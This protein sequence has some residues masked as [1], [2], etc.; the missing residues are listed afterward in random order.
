MA[1]SEELVA[2]YQVAK[3]TLAAAKERFDKVENELVQ[4]M[5]VQEI[6]SDLVCV[7]GKDYKVTVV[8]GESV[9]VDEIGLEK[10]LG[11]RNFKRLCSYR[12]DKKLLEA[13]LTDPSIPLSAETAA[14]FITIVPNKPYVKVSDYKEEE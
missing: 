6:K 9:R 12:V 3:A 1:I 7:R 2:E 11:K 13:A 4:D 14:K 10:Y 8:A 5:L